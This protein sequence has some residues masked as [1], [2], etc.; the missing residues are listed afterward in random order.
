MKILGV[1]DGHNAAAALVIDGRVVAAVQEERFNRVKNWSGFPRQA[2]RFVLRQA[3]LRP[4][5]LDAVAMDGL[6]MPYP[7]TRA[8][9]LEEYRTTGSPGTRLRRVVRRSALRTVYGNR[10]RVQRLRAVLELGVP[11]ERVRF[12]EHHTAHASAAYYGIG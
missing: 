1:H 2:T 4:A 6:H 10:R 5:D 12:V 11:E 3:G 7:K 8:Q 9:L